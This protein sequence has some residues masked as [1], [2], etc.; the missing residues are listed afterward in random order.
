MLILS[1]RERDIIVGLVVATL[2]AIQQTQAE[3]IMANLR[4]TQLNGNP[5]ASLPATYISGS[6]LTSA[7][8]TPIYAVSNVNSNWGCATYT[9]TQAQSRFISIVYLNTNCSV[10]SQIDA[11]SASGANA[12]IIVDYFDNASSVLKTSSK[13]AILYL[14][15]CCC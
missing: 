11:A 6:P 9:N 7:N 10:D 4:F 14:F 5:I 15:C 2:V 12:L 1:S 3:Q 13:F 8:G